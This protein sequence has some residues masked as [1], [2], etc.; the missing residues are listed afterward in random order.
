VTLPE[1]SR[2]SAFP[3]SQRSIT[4][5]LTGSARNS[6]RIVAGGRPRRNH[7]VPNNTLSAIVDWPK[8]R[9]GSQP[10][11]GSAR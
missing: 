8:R 1:D 10:V 11:P 6:S 9:R 2:R 7:P 3:E 4:A 5:G